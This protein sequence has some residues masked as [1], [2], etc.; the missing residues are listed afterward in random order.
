LRCAAA[1]LLAALIAPPVL[2]SAQIAVK[3][4]CANCHTVNRKLVG[5]SYKDIAVKYK[6][7]PDALPRLIQRVRKGG[8]GTWGPVP[9]PASDP[10]RISDADLKAVITWML[11]TPG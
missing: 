7:K 10:A 9:M 3:A 11:A 5:P 1:V 8:P 4:G 2:A 6:G